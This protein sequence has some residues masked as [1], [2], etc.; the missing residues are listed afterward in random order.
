MELYALLKLGWWCVLGIVLVGT[1]TL[2]GSDMGV[3]ALLRVVARSDTERR[4]CLNAIGPH[5]EGNQTWFVLG[6][7]ASFAAFPLLYA[8]A[9]SALYLVMLL[10]LWSMLLRPV[11][12]EYRSKLPLRAWREAW[13]WALVLGGALPMLL[14][15]CAF[16]QLLLG[17]GF[18]LDWNLRSS[19]QVHAGALLRPFALLCGLLA[20]AL[21]TLQGAAVLVQRCAGAVARRARLA[22][23]SAGACALLLFAGASVWA[24]RLDGWLLLSHPGAAV[25]QS[26]LQQQV[27]VRSGAWQANFGQHPLLWLLPLL[28]ALAM[29]AAAACLYARHA[30]AAWHLG[31]LAWVGVLGT[32]GA[33]LFP[34]VLPSS[35]HPG[36][37]LTV[38]NAASSSGA[39]LWMSGFTAVLLPLVLWY[40]RWCFRIMRGSVDGD[41]I[42]GSDHAY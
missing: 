7:G 9:F 30:R 10:L 22:G 12:F 33:S 19:Y 42:E 25:M 4:V 24:S 41:E 15:G 31:T 35:T 34:F 40:T 39:L 17:V 1:A 21:A 38:W 6:G 16:G 3:G 5:W 27:L 2:M 32:A 13:D 28:G 18:D 11:G 20:L 29:P 37:S 23:A 36:H 14:F 26:P 8:T